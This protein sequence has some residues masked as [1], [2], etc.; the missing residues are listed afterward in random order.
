MVR[1]RLHVFNFVIIIIFY[2]YYHHISQVIGTTP[3]TSCKEWFIIEQCRTEKI[4]QH[5]ETKLQQ[6]QYLLFS[7]CLSHVLD[8]KTKHCELRWN[9]I[10]W[11]LCFSVSGFL[12]KVFKTVEITFSSFQ[13]LTILLPYS[14]ILTLKSIIQPRNL[15]EKLTKKRRHVFHFQAEGVKEEQKWMF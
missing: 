4:I 15:S 13:H 14:G 12:S 10:A 6:C 5:W 9:W 8:H 2:Y 11:S 1:F 3:K 7:T